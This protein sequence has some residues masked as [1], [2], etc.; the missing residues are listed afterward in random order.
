MLWNT[1]NKNFW[2]FFKRCV[3]AS[4][5]KG[6]NVNRFQS[7]GLKLYF[8]R[9]GFFSW[10]KPERKSN[11]CN[12]YLA[13]FSTSIKC[14]ISKLDEINEHLLLPINTCLYSMS[15]QSSSKCWAWFCLLWCWLTL[16]LIQLLDASVV[17]LT[18]LEELMKVWLSK[19]LTSWPWK[20]LI[21]VTLMKTVA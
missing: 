2:G 5:D 17:D 6:Q 20:L 21:F 11:I 4:L 12:V 1:Q 10:M 7:Q 3:W 14:I 13:L 19:T 15:V 16:A 9:H 18:A 8:S